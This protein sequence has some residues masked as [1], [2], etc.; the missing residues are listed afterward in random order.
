MNP[1]DIKSPRDSDGHGTHTASTAAGNPLGRA[2]ML[3]LGEGTSR[4][5]VPSARIAVYK[6]CWSDGCE[7]VDVMNAFDDAIADGVDLLSASLGDFPENDML[8]DPLS[9]GS[10]HAMQHGILTIF[11][12]G[13]HGPKPSSIGNVSPWSI[14]VA[15]GTIDRKFITKVQLGDNTSYE[16]NYLFFYPM[17]FGSKNIKSHNGLIF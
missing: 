3:G 1:K 6:V 14:N 4:G 17:L 5:G 7:A 8:R 12:G 2:S 15:A 16:V 10:L 11:A 9:I 13:N